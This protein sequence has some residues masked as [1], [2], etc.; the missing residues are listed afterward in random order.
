M[1]QKVDEKSFDVRS[2][3]ILRA[4]GQWQL[5]TAVTPVTRLIGHDHE[6][7]IS[8][9]AH[10][11]I[12]LVVLKAHNLLDILDLFVLHDLVVLRLAHIEQLA[13]QREDA[14]IITPDNT[15]SGHGERLGGVSF[16]QYE[17]AL[18]RVAGSG[19]VCV[20]ELGDPS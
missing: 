1:V 11:G 16:G 7:S 10:I 3:V 4:D 2:V 18:G 20:R 17:C 5:P 8:Q 15:E 9:A 6:L 19:V 14:K 12:V 13:A